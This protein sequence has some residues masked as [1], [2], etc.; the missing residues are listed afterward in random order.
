MK[1][2][3][4]LITT[5]A[6]TTLALLALISMEAV[7]GLEIGG[8][9]IPSFKKTSYTRVRGDPIKHSQPKRLQGKSL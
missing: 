4:D 7:S 5:T 3:K 8:I 6:A 2:R 1:I 9:N